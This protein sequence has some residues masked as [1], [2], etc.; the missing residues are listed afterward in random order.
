M[1]QG[2]GVVPI[3]IELTPEQTAALAPL[4]AVLAENEAA[5]LAVMAQVAPEAMFAVV[6]PA[7]PARKVQAVLKEYRSSIQALQPA[8]PDPLRAK[9]Q[10]RSSMTRFPFVDDDGSGGV[11]A[12]W[13]EEEATA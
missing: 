11:I 13:N 1:T 5:K 4:F 12:W 2:L 8:A 7:A 9:L 6:L 3:R 10:Y